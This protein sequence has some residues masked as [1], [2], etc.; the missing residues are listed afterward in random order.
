M[1]TLTNIPLLIYSKIMNILTSDVTWSNAFDEGN[2]IRM[3]TVE[4]S[5]NPDKNNTNSGDFPQFSLKLKSGTNSM[6]TTDETFQTH[7]PEGPTDWLEDS[8]WRFRAQ[9][10]SQ[11]LS[12]DELCSLDEVT[13]NTLR[14]AGPKIGLPFVVRWKMSFETRETDSGDSDGTLRMIT[15]MDLSFDTQIE[16]HISTGV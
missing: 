11:K 9:I 16:A 6:F 3:D 1:S 7:S 12:V 14:K 15:D 8:S 10:I 2:I 4:G 5:E 13:I